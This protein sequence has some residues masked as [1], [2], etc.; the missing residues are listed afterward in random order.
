MAFQPATQA[1]VESIARELGL[2]FDAADTAFFQKLLAPFGAM[3]SLLDACPDELP[4]VRY[5][6][7]PGARLRSRTTCSWRESR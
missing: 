5:P 7:T 1:E 2:H 6:R 4:T 3:T